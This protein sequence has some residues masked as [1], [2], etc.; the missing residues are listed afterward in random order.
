MT[1]NVAIVEDDKKIRESLC[2]LIEGSPG[3]KCISA[4]EDAEKALQ[5]IPDAIPDVV[6]MDINLPK[7]SGI[8]CVKHLKQQLPGILIIMLTMYEDIQKIFSSLQAGAVGYL[9]KSTSPSEILQAI[10]DVHSGGSPM[11]SQIARK[12]VQSFFKTNNNDDDTIKLSERER[13]ILNLLAKGYINKE[14]ADQLFISPDTVH[15]HLRNIYEKLHVRT[16]TEAVVKF[17]RK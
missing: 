16:R 7:M 3:F 5:N 12:V 10:K 2:I 13:E 1:I 4:Y 8:E 17:L 6:L 14:I 11:T 9:I 15:N